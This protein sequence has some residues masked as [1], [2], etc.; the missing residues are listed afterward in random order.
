V[1]AEQVDL[2]RLLDLC[3]SRLHLNLEYDPATVKGA[4]T[5][6]FPTAIPDA[7]LWT[8]TN[9]L[10]AA[11]GFT[12]VQMAGE[13]TLS[14]V[15]LAEAAGVA[16]IE[17]GDPAAS[18]AGFVRVVRH[19]QNRP[20]KELLAPLQL[21]LSKPGGSATQAEG[22]DLLV[23]ADLK[24]QLLKA[25]EVLA[26]IDVPKSF[27]VVQ[28]V[29]AKHLKAT[30]LTTLVDR[31][32]TTQSGV[33]AGGSIG[34]LIAAPDERRILVIAPQAQVARILD[35][36]ERFDQKEA[37]TTVTYAPKS[38]GVKDVSRLVDQVLSG[39]VKS[40][41]APPYQIVEDDLT[42]TLLLTATASQ[43]AKVAELLLRLDSTATATRRPIRAFKLKNRSV[44]DV[45]ALLQTLIAAGALEAKEEAAPPGPGERPASQVSPPETT[46]PSSPAQTNPSPNNPAPPSNP[47][48]PGSENRG[49]A[50]AGGSGRVGAQG[51]TS[52]KGRTSDAEN[53]HG[54][55]LSADAGTNSLIAVGDIHVLD[56]IEKLLQTLD[57]RQPQVMLEALVLA[58]TDSQA[59]ELGVEMQKLV[60]SGSVQGRLSSLFGLGAPDPGTGGL[61]LASGTGFTGVVLNPGSFSALVHALETL[62]HGRTLT[63][64]RVLVNNNQQGRLD[65]VLQ[66][67][68]QSTNA[69][70]TVATT[71]F[72]GTQD[73]GTTIT[74][75]PQIS[76]GDHL[77]LDY[78][79]SVSAFVGEATSPSLPPPRQQNKI[80]SSVTIPDG[81][82]IVVGGLQIDSQTNGSSQLP[83]LADIPLLGWLF[84]STT[85]NTTHS[86]LFVFLRADVMRGESF[87][88]LKYLSDD[89][90]REGEIADDGP[91]VE[92]RMVR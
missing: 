73:A 46:P 87:E 92:P 49:D 12:T 56:Q 91:T 67:P 38:F 48:P 78:D 13:K 88:F 6:R 26:L 84:R 86:K 43:H 14:V 58:L 21:V 24:P 45:L 17:D 25:L 63:I 19:A 47:K 29:E 83:W 37:Q 11:H 71:S 23:V 1:L 31:V 59:R 53:E 89:A 81:Y 8:L 2:A 7:D 22:A 64:P 20:S 28:E 79:V 57:V 33:D 51:G 5:F 4:I 39:E 65:S 16:R 68:F 50:G 72:G 44:A 60:T 85:E 35:L 10:L 27:A 76:E 74:V 18:T 70:T 54:V 80:Q 30:E 15:K 32:L 52:G 90:R 9:R 42:G 3:A 36:I 34:K 82:T 66:T 62:N 69:S 75:K 55:S 41:G 77:L 61:P 40:K